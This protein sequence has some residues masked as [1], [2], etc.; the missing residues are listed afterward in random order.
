MDAMTHTIRNI[1]ASALFAGILVPDA[2]AQVSYLERISCP[3][4]PVRIVTDEPVKGGSGAKQAELSFTFDWD[5]GRI[6]SQHTAAIVP[7]LVSE[8]GSRS[9]SFDPIFID[10]RTRAKAVDRMETLSG[11]E[12]PEGSIVLRPDRNGGSGAVEYVSRIQYDP[13]MLD[14]SIVFHETVSGCAGCIEG[15]DSLALGV[16]P[17]YVPEWRFS[18]SPAGGL[19]HRELRERA[20]L[21][22][23][24]NLHD[25]NPGYADN[26]AVLDKVMS[27][28]R[29]AGD[30]SL[31]TVT[32]VRFIGYASPDGPEAFNRTLALNRAKSLMNYVMEA[33]EAIPDSLFT[34][35]SIGEDW[36]GLFA[37]AA[38]DP[39]VAG[40]PTLARVREELNDGNW[41]ACE[42][43][44]KGD[45]EL[46]DYLR[47]N[48]LPSLRRTEY[49]IEYYIR[50]F[51][52]E[53][54]AQLWDERPELL[55]VDEFKA[56]AGLY[57]KDS[58]EYLKILLAAA[59]TWPDDPA[60]VNNAAMALYEAGDNARAGKLLEGRGEALLQNALGIIRAGEGDYA[61]A[62][63]LFESASA[64]GNSEA[65]H[66]LTELKNVLYQLEQ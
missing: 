28:V 12:R 38:A 39:A 7:V 52:A 26:A 25:I 62:L 47:S 13:A 32:S 61:A 64:A 33:D 22:F 48:I 57:G 19:K 18:P 44:L 53:E 3:K 6:A 49:S 23:I 55:S 2:G 29:M 5:G 41:A 8:D 14:G 31:Y 56:A 65:A 60:A 54:A 1:F 16:L 40:N 9:F 45:T 10:G 59:E 51:S 30:S 11:I 34:F 20:D 37:A 58:G 50:H 15:E 24:V 35:E 46:Y 43:L 66:N 4:D 63:R 42:R 27:S 21:K 17:R 36:E